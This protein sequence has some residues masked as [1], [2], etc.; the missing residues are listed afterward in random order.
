M[1]SVSTEKAKQN[2]QNLIDITLDN[3]DL[4]NIV[5]DK[6][7]VILLNETNYNNL[8]LTLEVY[9]NSNFKNSLLENINHLEEFVDESEVDW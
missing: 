9:K 8:M 1:Y 7:N 6:G 2:L 5:S 3:E 4:V